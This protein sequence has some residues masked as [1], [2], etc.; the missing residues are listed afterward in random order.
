MALR[1]DELVL[2]LCH[3]AIDAV[4]GACPRTTLNVDSLALNAVGSW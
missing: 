4:D 3:G 1:I 2:E